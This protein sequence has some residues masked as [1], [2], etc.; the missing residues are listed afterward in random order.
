MRWKDIKIGMKISLGFGFVILLIVIIG[1]NSFTTM[2]KIRKN[3]QMLSEEQLPLL[4]SI[5]EAGKSWHE[6][7]ELM[8]LY[9]NTGE[10]FYADQVIE[11]V[12]ALVQAYE[13]LDVVLQARNGKEGEIFEEIREQIENYSKVLERYFS[14][15][16]ILGEQLDSLELANETFLL[17]IKE[18]ISQGGI[19]VQK[20]KRISSLL[21]KYTQYG[22]LFFGYVN[23]KNTRELSK[24][25]EDYKEIKEEYGILLSD[26]KPSN[27]LL[28][29]KIE[30]RISAF[31]EYIREYRDCRK[32]EFKHRELG[33][34]IRGNIMNTS[35]IGSEQ[36]LAMGANTNTL[37]GTSLFWML[38]VLLSIVLISLVFAVMISNS[39]SRPLVKGVEITNKI[40]EGDLTQIIELDR[41]DEVGVLINSINRISSNLQKIVKQLKSSSSQIKSASGEISTSAQQLSFGAAT[42]A[43]S[44]DQLSKM[45]E[46]IKEN[47]EYATENARKTRDI[48]EKSSA[49]MEKGNEASLKV[50]DSINSITKEILVVGDIAFQTNLLA[51][52]AA[53]EAARA[54]DYGKGFS[55]VASEVKKLAER[56]AEAAGKIDEISKA[57]MDVSHFSSSKISELTPDIQQT[58][59]LVDGI[60]KMNDELLDSIVTVNSSIQNLNNVIQSNSSSSEELAASSEEL[61]A[62]ADQLNNLVDIFKTRKNNGAAAL[63]EQS[64]F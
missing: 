28:P 49:G 5:N 6:I 2:R 34:L 40:A 38:V 37:I 13:Q 50:Q 51:L 47:I 31:Q 23:E 11:R 41:K 33:H 32:L 4:N 46:Q 27:M 3:T 21:S 57:T 26:A 25:D 55:V 36:I 14:T 60:T 56:S 58:A 62:Q 59:R 54:G 19:S 35:D 12:G 48:A 64:V 63:P 18:Q 20:A 9:D 43:S 24:L 44:S 29:G 10:Q 7:T 39:I 17:D 52:N 61:T 16:K 45:V 42:Q 30:G 53:V 8:N 15:N 1:I 22:M